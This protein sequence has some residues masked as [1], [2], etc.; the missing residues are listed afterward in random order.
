MTQRVPETMERF[1]RELPLSTATMTPPLISAAAPPPPIN[2]LSHFK[3]RKGQTA[4]PMSGVPLLSAPRPGS[5]Q[6]PPLPFSG[7]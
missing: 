2:R 6:T 4:M 7:E 1:I 5:L 3:S